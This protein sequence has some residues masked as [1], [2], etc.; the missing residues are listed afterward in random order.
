MP[1]VCLEYLR[2]FIGSDGYFYIC[3]GIGGGRKLTLWL[4]PFLR[5]GLGSEMQEP[6]S[7]TAHA[8]ALECMRARDDAK[9]LWRPE[10]EIGKSVRDAARQRIR[11]IN[12]SEGKKNKTNNNNRFNWLKPDSSDAPDLQ[13]LFVHVLASE[14]KPQHPEY[15]SLTTIS[16]ES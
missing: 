1:P 16:M 9:Y 15:Q 6:E 10:A 11:D 12:E 13:Q 2:L 5:W 14:I 4:N 8:A 3:A 7:T